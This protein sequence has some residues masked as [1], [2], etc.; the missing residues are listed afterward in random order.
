MKEQGFFGFTAMKG[1]LAGLTGTL[2]ALGLGV[3]VAQE[4]GGRPSPGPQGPEEG[5]YR[6]QLWL[7]PSRDTTALMRTT[8]FRP[9]GRG[10]FPLAVIMHGSVQSAAERRKFVQPV[11]A[12]AAEFFVQRGFAVAVPQRPGHGETGGP[13]LEHQGSPCERADYRKAGLAVA[14][15]IEAAIAYMTRQPFV[16]RDGVIVVGQS[17]GG[18]GSLALASRNP[19]Q[20]KGIVN[21]A[22]G[23]G[24]RAND[25]PKTNCAP[26][27]LIEAAGA[28]GATARLPVLSIYTENDS[29]FPPLLSRQIADAYRKAGGN[30]DFHLLPAFGKDG[31]RLLG[32]HEGVAVWGPIVD[33]FL[34]TLK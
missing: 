32:A 15:S 27:R 20:V 23:R 22:G 13:Y 5:Q 8:V 16:K 24:G 34:K 19:P 29:Y 17:A 12:A 9:A 31:H 18:W 30:M 33:G 28:F 26:E 6:R 14:D 7:V 10:P 2:L 3:A 1:L 25:R 21:F 11:F 4:G